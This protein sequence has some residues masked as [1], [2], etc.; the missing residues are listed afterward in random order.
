MTNFWVKSTIIRSV[1]ALKNF[2]FINKIIYNFMILVATKTGRTKKTSPSPS[3][4][5]VV[6]SEICD[7][8]SVMD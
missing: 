5:A 4:G 7:P 3:F 8:G 1:L 2:Q 6:G